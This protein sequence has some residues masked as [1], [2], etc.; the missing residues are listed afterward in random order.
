MDNLKM[1]AKSEEEIQKQVQRVKN[2]SDDIHLEF[3]LGLKNVPRLHLR[4]AN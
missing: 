3:G 1:T 2:F 4:E